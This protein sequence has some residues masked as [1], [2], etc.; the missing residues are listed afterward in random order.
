MGAFVNLQKKKISRIIDHNMTIGADSKENLGEV[1]SVK[2][3]PE[4]KY[5]AAAMGNGTIQIYNTLSG[6]VS[7]SLTHQQSSFHYESQA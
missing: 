1:Y 6:K 7:Y 5:L 2:F 4:D 3:D